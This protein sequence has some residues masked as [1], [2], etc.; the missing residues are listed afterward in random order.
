MLKT[1]FEIGADAALFEGL[2]IADEKELCELQIAKESIF[3]GLNNFKVRTVSDI[4]FAE[5][6]GF[7]DQEVKQLLDDYDLGDKFDLFK[8][9][10]DGYRFGNIHVY[11]PWDVLNQ[12]EKFCMVVKE[13]DW[14]N[15]PVI[16]ISEKR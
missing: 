14:E 6:F 3:T 9:W 11:C 15:V 4:R 10:Y 8:E 7:T 5:Y 13:G 12:C 16:L 2:K 1:F